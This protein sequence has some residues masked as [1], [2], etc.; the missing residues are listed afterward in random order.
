MNRFFSLALAL[1]CLMS[2][3]T[4]AS[5]QMYARQDSYQKLLSKY[6]YTAA[7]QS[8]IRKH[9]YNT[10]DPLRSTVVILSR[11]EPDRRVPGYFWGPTVKSIRESSPAV[12]HDLTINVRGI[13]KR[14]VDVFNYA[15]HGASKR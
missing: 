6:P 14:D 8:L 13:A 1:L 15:R 3:A 11:C 9:I 7:L 4:V 2:S 10:E 5:A 12:T